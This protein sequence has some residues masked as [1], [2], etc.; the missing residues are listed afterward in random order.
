MEI[1]QNKLLCETYGQLS[2]RIE[3]EVLPEVEKCF[4]G[5]NKILK[6]KIRENDETR[7]QS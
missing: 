4:E 5:Y 2:K 7:K 6:Q 1:F 3:N